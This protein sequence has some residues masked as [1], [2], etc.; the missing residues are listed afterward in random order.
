MPNKYEREIE[1]ILRNLE[2]TE[3]KAG[4]GQ[5]FSER[6]RKKPAPRMRSRPSSNFSLTLTTSDWLLITAIGIALI[7]GGYEFLNESPTPVTGLLAIMGLI[8][9]VLV[10]FSQFVF[11]PRRPSSLRYGNTT[12]TPLRRGPLHTLQTRWNLFM[13]KMRYRKRNIR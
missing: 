1:E 10:A 5:K 13:L 3:P 9:I 4:I 12:I 8:C 6:L 11:R 2:Q 7:A